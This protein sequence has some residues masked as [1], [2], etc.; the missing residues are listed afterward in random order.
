MLSCQV[1][2]V[3]RGGADSQVLPLV[4]HSVS[5]YIP[6]P[7]PTGPQQG[8]VGVGPWTALPG[9]MRMTFERLLSL[10]WGVFTKLGEGRCWAWLVSG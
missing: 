10:I 5:L 8:W 2:W 6:V 1:L 9:G 4:P 3:L 7:C